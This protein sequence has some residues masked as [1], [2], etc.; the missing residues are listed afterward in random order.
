MSPI[1]LVFFDASSAIEAQVEGSSRLVKE[2]GVAISGKD[3]PP[4]FSSP[5]RPGPP[6]SRSTPL[7]TLASLNSL[8]EVAT[9]VDDDIHLQSLLYGLTSGVQRVSNFPTVS[10]WLGSIE[11]PLSYLLLHHNNKVLSVLLTPL[12]TLKATTLNL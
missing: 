10:P 7:P 2:K 12:T 11:I 9:E 8:A 3:V 5:T 4:S 6:A 1:A